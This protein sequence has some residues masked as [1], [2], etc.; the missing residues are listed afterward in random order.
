MDSVF[1]AR[2]PGKW[3]QDQEEEVEGLVCRARMV[4]TQCATLL[5]LPGRCEANTVSMVCSFV[6]C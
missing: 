2:D 4:V 1:R 3:G 6:L 5:N